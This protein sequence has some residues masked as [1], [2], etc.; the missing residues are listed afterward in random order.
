MTIDG[1]KRVDVKNLKN[2]MRQYREKSGLTYY[3]ISESLG[4]RGTSTAFRSLTDPTK[5]SDVTLSQIFNTIGM[6]CLILIKGGVKY[7]YIKK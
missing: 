1:Y 4:F 2:L 3:D 5:A 7:Y 6:D